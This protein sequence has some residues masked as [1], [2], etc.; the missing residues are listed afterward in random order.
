[1]DEG[2]ERRVVSIPRRAVTERE[3][4]DMDVDI[5]SEES[6]DPPVDVTQALSAADVGREGAEEAEQVGAW[7]RVGEGIEIAEAR[8]C[9][10]RVL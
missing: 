10:R 3:G 7:R 8:L 6:I 4:V 9:A 2:R 1:V 5:M